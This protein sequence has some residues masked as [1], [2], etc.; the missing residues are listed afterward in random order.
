MPLPGEQRSSWWVWEPLGLGDIAWCKAIPANSLLYHRPPSGRHLATV[1]PWPCF[2]PG[3][4]LW[5]SLEGC[6]NG[7]GPGWAGHPSA[8]IGVEAQLGSPSSSSLPSQELA[9]VCMEGG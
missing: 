2:L 5:G 7:A 6:G 4:M 9:L 1:G 8:L 3:S